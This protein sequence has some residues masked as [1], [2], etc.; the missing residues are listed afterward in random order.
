MVI[1]Y[2]I[3]PVAPQ[4]RI[5]WKKGINYAEKQGLEWEFIFSYKQARKQGDSIKES[6]LFALCEWDLADARYRVDWTTSTTEP[7][8]GDNR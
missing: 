2:P 1:K 4:D 8:K 6:I 7:K 5:L 3:I